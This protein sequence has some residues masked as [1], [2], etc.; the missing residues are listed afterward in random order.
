[1]ERQQIHIIPIKKEDSKANKRYKHFRDYQAWQ[2]AVYICLLNSLQI[3]NSILSIKQLKFENDIIDVE[4]F[5]QLRSCDK[6]K[7]DRISGVPNKTASRRYDNNK[8]SEC[9]HLLMDI[10]IENGYFVNARKSN[11][12][13]NT[14][15]IYSARE[16]FYES[17]LIATYQDIIAYGKNINDYLLKYIKSNEFYVLKRNDP[18]L[19]KQFDANFLK[20]NSSNNNSFGIFT[21]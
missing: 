20:S 9:L 12:R 10:L 2:Q 1:M 6:L 13:N 4:N 16:I 3:N 8:F 18:F 21:D 5:L 15:T 7:R 11:G 19:S 17:K 14:D